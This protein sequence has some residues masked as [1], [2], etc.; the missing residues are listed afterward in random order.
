MLS[1]DW[2]LCWRLLGPKLILELLHVHARMMPSDNFG[3][4]FI[5]LGEFSL[6]FCK[7][8]LKEAY[9][10]GFVKGKVFC[11]RYPHF[12]FWHGESTSTASHQTS[13]AS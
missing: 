1:V 7:G 3:I 4:G 8:E 11:F 6:V 10:Q 9:I 2:L 12:Y 13:P 5:L